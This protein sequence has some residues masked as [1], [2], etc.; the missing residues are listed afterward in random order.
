MADPSV[1]S[2]AQHSFALLGLLGRFSDL[3]RGWGLLLNPLDDAYCYGLTHITHCKA[4]WEM[5]IIRKTQL[6]YYYK[7]RVFHLFKAKN[8]DSGQRE[9]KK[10]PGIK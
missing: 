2:P 6:S 3:P 9:T 5:N 8:K 1:R 7:S 4:T 10:H